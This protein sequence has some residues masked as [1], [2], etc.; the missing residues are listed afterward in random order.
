MLNVKPDIMFIRNR[1]RSTPDSND[2]L[3]FS[4]RL[5]AVLVSVV[6]NFSIFIVFAMI[7]QRA[8][9][10]AKMLLRQ[11]DWPIVL[12]VLVP[13]IAGF[14]MGTSRFATLLGHCFY[15]NME[16]E[17]DW[18]ITAVLWAGIIFVAYLWSQLA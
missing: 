6:F 5:T 13:A 2:E 14:L 7:H 17:K 1:S 12:M 4:N 9:H 10:S 8:F 18:R 16:N 3:S 15:T 11:L